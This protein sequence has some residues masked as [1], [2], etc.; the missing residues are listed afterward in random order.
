MLAIGGM[1]ALT[2]M[3][4]QQTAEADDGKKMVKIPWAEKLGEG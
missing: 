4:M 1:A 2:S 3:Y